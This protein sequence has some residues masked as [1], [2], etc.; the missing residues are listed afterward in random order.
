[1]QTT[2]SREES[3]L[4]RR[5]TY[6]TQIPSASK[7]TFELFLHFKSMNDNSCL[8]VFIFTNSQNRNVHLVKVNV[9]VT[10]KV[11]V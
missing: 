8:I 1:M 10:V 11:I 2:N 6:P 3:K 9:Q 4:G 7:I 5:Q